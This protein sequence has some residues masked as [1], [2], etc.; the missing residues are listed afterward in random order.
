MIATLIRGKGGKVKQ[1][2]L[3]LLMEHEEGLTAREISH[4]LGKEL[5]RYSYLFQHLRALVDAGLV[6]KSGRRYMLTDKQ[7][8]ARLLDP[9]RLKLYWAGHDPAPDI[10]AE[11][12]GKAPI[13]LSAGTYW[14]I[15]RF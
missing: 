2:I 9:P 12:F 3:K 15:G 8:V 14:Y 4:R 13:L 5:R 7:L 6:R 11:L 10:L 1:E